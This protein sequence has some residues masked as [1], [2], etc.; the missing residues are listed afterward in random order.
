MKVRVFAPPERRNSVWIGG[1]VLGA[2]DFFRE[3]MAVSR[4]EY[5]EQGAAIVHRKC[6]S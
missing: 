1:S 6:H 3:T 5:Q 2:R 4:K